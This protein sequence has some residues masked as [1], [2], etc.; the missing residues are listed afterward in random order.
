MKK[1]IVTTADDNRVELLKELIFS[2]KRFKQL[3]DYDIC[4]LSTNLSK[5]NILYLSKFASNIVERAR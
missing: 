5:E 4:I 2:I 1:T 3:D